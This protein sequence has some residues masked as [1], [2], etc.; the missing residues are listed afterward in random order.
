M[1]ACCSM[2]RKF[3][4]YMVQQEEEHDDDEKE[5]G[6]REGDF[7]SRVMLR[8][9][10][11]FASMFTQKGRKGINQDAMTIWEDFAGEKDLI[12]CAVF[13]GHGPYGHKVAG[14]VR[15]A[16]P[17][18]LS[19]RLKSWKLGEYDHKEDGNDA[20]SDDVGHY[21]ND[22]ANSQDKDGGESDH[23]RSLCSLKTCFVK[24]FEDMDEELRQ[25]S[26]IESYCS[27]TTAVTVL[28]KGEHL[29]I[30]N[31]GDSRAVLCTIDNKNQLV[32]IQLTVDLKPNI[33][34]EAERIRRCGGRVFAMEDERDVYRVWVP[35]EDYP[36]LAMARAFADFCLKDFGLI[37]TPQVSYRK[38][39]DKDEF[40]VMATDG[41]WDVLSN[42]EVV[43]IV[44][45]AQKRCMAAKLLVNHA[46][47]A[48]ENKYPN[49]KVDDCAVVCLFL[50]QQSSFTKTTPVLMNN[51]SRNRRLDISPSVKIVGLVDGAHETSEDTTTATPKEE[52]TAI[53]GFSRNNSI[54]KLPRVLDEKI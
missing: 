24:A 48:W 6:R 23:N 15:D 3:E 42:E 21:S 52:W 10:C 45:S 34:S 11:E 20:S 39:T 19:S 35:D 22:E 31:L 37:S 46:C 41:V 13:D 5:N 14:C 44:A 26:T 2:N 38:I 9:S 32:P 28:K 54:L 7:G 40:V 4:G 33:P 47:Q 51:E 36:G 1:G 17:S 25:D 50:K 27:G 43:E 12:F 53:K 18:K 49:S 30:A 29:I 16:L 8:G